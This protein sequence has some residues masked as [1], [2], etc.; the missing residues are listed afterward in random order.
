M[1]PYYEY[2]KGKGWVITPSI[3]AQL[4]EGMALFEYRKPNVGEKYVSRA[5]RE[6]LDGYINYVLTRP[7]YYRYEYYKT[8]DGDEDPDCLHY[9]TLRML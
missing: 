1:E 9:A 4:V 2:V 7:G 5:T 6:E 8:W 3:V